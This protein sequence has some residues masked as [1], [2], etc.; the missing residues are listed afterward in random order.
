M[1]AK[2][3][4]YRW[5]ILPVLAALLLSACGSTPAAPTAS[6]DRTAPTLESPAA[7]TATVPEAT[8]KPAATPTPEASP[9]PQPSPTPVEWT[10]SA[11]NAAALAPL[12]AVETSR[13][14]QIR[15]ADWSPDGSSLAVA[16]ETTLWLLDAATWQPAWQAEVAAAARVRFSPDGA[17]LAVQPE[18]GATRILD[19]ASGEPVFEIGNQPFAFSA[20]GSLVVDGT[21]IYDTATGGQVRQLEAPAF[22]DQTWENPTAAAFNQDASQVLMGM[23]GGGFYRWD[24]ATGALLEQIPGS[25]VHRSCVGEGESGAWLVMVCEIPNAAYTVISMKILYSN[26]RG[27]FV[28][29]NLQSHGLTDSPYGMYTLVPGQSTL[30]WNIGGII[31]L[32]NLRA[33][34]YATQPWQNPLNMDGFAIHT[35]D[36]GTRVAAWRGGELQIWDP[37]AGVML[38]DPGGALIAKI[39]F[40]PAHPRRLAYARTSGVLALRDLAASQPLLYTLAAPAGDLS[41]TFSPDGTHLASAGSDGDIKVWDASGGTAEPVAVRTLYAEPLVDVAWS[42]DGS[43]VAA[44]IR[45]LYSYWSWQITPA[46]DGEATRVRPADLYSPYPALAFS[47]D[48]NRMA[49]GTEQGIIQLMD[50]RG[51]NKVMQLADGRMITIHHLAFSPDS[52]LLAASGSGLWSIKTGRQVIRLDETAWSAA[53]SPDQCLLAAGMEDGTIALWDV[54]SRKLVYT[55]AAFP[56]AVS[57]LAFSPDGLLLAAGSEGGAVTVFGVPGALEQAGGTPAVKCKP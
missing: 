32:H 24:A 6:P 49:L 57:D 34:L 55:L 22:T 19:A 17:R 9:T 46:F 45:S 48:G 23:D 40:D 1:T 56:N 26:L 52:S 25:N 33:S 50:G 44:G 20:D 37:G 12:M 14:G 51:T 35:G 21:F 29:A 4:P 43:R 16:D 41:L 15:A 39:A 28:T 2:K 5:M 42:P 18:E 11:G 54:M 13:F 47:P 53:L 7:A 10:I 31:T 3:S 36:A 8:P 30:A 27:A 38:A